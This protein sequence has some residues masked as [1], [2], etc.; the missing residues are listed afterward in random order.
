[1]AGDLS[2]I[3]AYVYRPGRE[4]FD[5]ITLSIAELTLEERQIIRAGSLI[6]YNRKKH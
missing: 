3:R 2:R 5:E 6:N 4:T 1:M